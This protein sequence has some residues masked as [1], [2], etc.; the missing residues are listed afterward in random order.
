[1]QAGPEDETDSADGAAAVRP[2]AGPSCRKPIGCRRRPRRIS[3]PSATASSSIPDAL[4]LPDTDRPLVVEGAGGLMVPLT[5]EI[6]LYRR[7]RALEC[8]GRALRPHHARHHQS[9]PAVDR[10]DARAA[11]FRL[12]GI[13][14]IGDE[15][16]ESRTHHL[17]TWDGAAAGPSAASRSADRPDAAGRFRRGISSVEDFLRGPC[18]MKSTSPVWHPFTQHAVQPDAAAD[19]ARRGRLAGDRRWPRASSMRSRPGG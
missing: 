15:N 3:P 5:R 13:A 14:F 10:S 1:M 12:L 17:P 19:R 11:T 7:L 16:E 2:C 18:M 8:A 9:Q 6:T 4:V